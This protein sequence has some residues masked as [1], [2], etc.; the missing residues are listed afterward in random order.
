MI[1]QPTVNGN[2]NP[3]GCG[4]PI[5]NLTSQLFS[6][7]YLSGL[8]DFVKR[9]LRFRHYGRYVDDFYIVSTS[10]EDLLAAIPLIRVFLSRELGLCLHPRKSHLTDVRKGVRFL[11]AVIK[12]Y[13]R[14]VYHRGLSRAREH[15]DKVLVG[16]HNPYVIK[17]VIQSY[18]GYQKH[19]MSYTKAILPGYSVL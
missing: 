1:Q 10:R 16:E 3:S 4:L 17:S 7:I 12:P 19:F 11:G 2:V 14:Y 9:E 18:A 6:N 13:Q 5:G 8:D 15:I